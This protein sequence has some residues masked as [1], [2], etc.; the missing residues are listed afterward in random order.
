[1]LGNAFAGEGAAGV[2]TNPIDQVCR[3]VSDEKDNIPKYFE[4][5]WE[6][7]TEQPR[8][9]SGQPARAPARPGNALN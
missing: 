4:P 1:M 7:E 3:D 5:V 2:Q 8:R 9:S 6:V